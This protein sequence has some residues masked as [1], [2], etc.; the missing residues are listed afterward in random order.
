MR[1]GKYMRIT[2]IK[3]T[4]NASESDGLILPE[5]D[6]RLENESPRTF[7][8][9]IVPIGFRQVAQAGSVRQNGLLNT[10]SDT[11]PPSGLRF[12]PHP[13][14]NVVSLMAAFAD[15][16]GGQT[17]FH[18][19]HA[20]IPKRSTAAKLLSLITSPRTCKAAHFHACREMQRRGLT[21][22]PRRWININ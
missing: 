15:P 10:L 12:Q 19:G 3:L 20:L 11:S 14:A 1:K 18:L 22:R 8:Y 13:V 21:N 16:L 5:C 17:R 4:H 7:C 9:T 6:D 2:H